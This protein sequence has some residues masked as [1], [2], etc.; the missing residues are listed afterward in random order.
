MLAF[1]GCVLW[2]ISDHFRSDIGPL[3]VTKDQAIS[4]AAQVIQKEFGVDVTA[5][6]D[7]VAIVQDD[8]ASTPSRFIWQVYGKDVYQGMQASYIQ[9]VSWL[10]R[11]MQFER[12]VEERGEEFKVMVSNCCRIGA[13]TPKDMSPKILAIEHKLPEHYQ[14][15][16]LTEEQ[17]LKKAYAYIEHEFDL[18]DNEISLISV[19]SDK[20]EHRRDWTIVVQDCAYFNF[21]QEGQARIQ[22]VISG[23]VVTRYSQ[24]IFVP[25]DWSRIDKALVIN[26]RIYLIILYLFMILFILLGCIFGARKLTVSQYGTKIIRHKLLFVGVLV[27]IITINNF[28]IYIGSFNTAEPFY[29]Q[30]TRILLQLVFS[31]VLQVFFCSTFLTIAAVGFIKSHK[32]KYAQAIGL[33]I[34][35][36]LF[37]VGVFAYVHQYDILSSSWF[38]VVS[39]IGSMLT[40][41][42][43]ALSMLA[44]IF[45]I[46][47]ALFAQWKYKMLMEF[48]SF[49]LFCC[50]LQAFGTSQSVEFM[51]A[52]G[53][54]M[55]AAMAIV[56]WLILQFDMTL[57]PLIIAVMMIFNALPEILH[58]SYAGSQLNTLCAIFV[59]IA[60]A[61][62]FYERSHIE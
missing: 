25:E 4:C 43:L 31:N 60:V 33:S 16:D 41:Y 9:G 24:F 29:D 7:V 35:A 15:A 11:F 58:P 1:I 12:P 36:G 23:D 27:A 49:M 32:P 42:C 51:I 54:L 46:I 34:A 56:Y 20:L 45:L 8:T 52:N 14:G 48:V 3:H 40:K 10:I 39:S 47:Q 19:A 62:F 53:L 26:I 5:N 2:V 50:A 37:L 44:S 55:G 13:V 22:I 18:Q 30:C 28:C 61:L 38:P 17:A 6:W 21:D 57:L 59:M